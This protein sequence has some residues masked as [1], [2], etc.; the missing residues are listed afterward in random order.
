[1]KCTATVIY[2]YQVYNVVSLIQN[3]NCVPNIN[4]MQLSS[5][6]KN[7]ERERERAD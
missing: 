2:R 7:K 5:L 6:Q 1:M 3:D 4:P